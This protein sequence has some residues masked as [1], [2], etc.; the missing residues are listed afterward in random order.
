MEVA[1]RRAVV[2]GL[3]A[4]AATLVLSDTASPTVGTAPPASAVDG[5]F[6]P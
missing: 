6:P 4:V 5:M 2:I 1:V 3:V